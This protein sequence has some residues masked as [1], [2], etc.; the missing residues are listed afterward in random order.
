MIHSR[1]LESPKNL[2]DS[3]G[4]PMMTYAVQNP[5]IPVEIIKRLLDQ[6]ANL[7][8][9]QYEG[10]NKRT[11]L[12]DMLEEDHAINYDKAKLLLERGTNPNVFD[13][14]YLYLYLFPIL[15]LFS[16]ISNFQYKGCLYD[17][18]RAVVRK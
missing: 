3:D 13:E 14:V 1:I 9:A 12:H 18:I 4:Y 5:K 6:K 10:D 15:G 2:V 8:Y 7:E 16:D 11:H 17:H